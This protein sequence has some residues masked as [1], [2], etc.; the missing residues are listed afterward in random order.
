MFV[1]FYT[2]KKPYVFA[3]RENIEYIEVEDDKY[4][5]HF[6][7][8]KFLEAPRSSDMNKRTVGQI[9]QETIHNLY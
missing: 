1:R 2:E 7:S 9:E 8:G 4:I 5:I 6:A 3:N